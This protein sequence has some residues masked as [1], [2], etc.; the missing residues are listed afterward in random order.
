MQFRKSKVKFQ[1][2]DQHGQPIQ[3][4][5]VSIKQNRPNFPFGVAI[6]KNILHNGAYQNWFKS[7]FKYTVFENELKW[8]STEYNR[9]SEDYST[10]DA[11]V[12]LAKSS[13]ATIRGHN[14]L[15]DD[16]K[17]QPNWVPGLSSNDLWAA[18]NKRVDSVVGR[19]RGQ[20]IHW[21]VVNENLHWNFLESKLGWN[22]SNNFYQRANKVDGRMTPFLNEYSTIEDSTDGASSPSKYLQR[23]WDMRK[24][25]YHGPLGIGAQGHFTNANLPYARSALDQLASA[26]LPIWITELDVKPGS[27]QAS[28]LE[29][30]LW[31]L[32]SHWAV[33]G[34]IMWAAWT[35]Q[36]CYTMCLTDG[37]FK[38][39]ATGDVVDKVIYKWTHAANTPAT[40]DSNGFFETSLYHGEY[41]VKVNHPKG[42]NFSNLKQINL[43]PNEKARDVY[44]FTINV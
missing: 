42:D 4:A 7:R 41:E 1:A 2:V 35:P 28:Y 43:V 31:E 23:I 32:H 34:I 25:G 36:G 14:V 15:W 16:A 13:G 21:D 3:N 44:R 11:M 30:I 27:N 19:Y 29:Q 39:L 9:G 5:T 20:L 37:N 12:K 17:F 40:T 18:A 26:K 22:A 24:N 8:V 10:S 6:N 33:Q 38:N